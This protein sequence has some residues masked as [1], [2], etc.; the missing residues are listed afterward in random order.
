VRCAAFAL[1]AILP[2]AV[3]AE[4]I[5]FGLFGDMPYSKW[6]RAQMPRLIEQ[7]DSENLAFVVHG[8]D[9]KSGSSVCSDA[10]FSD[11]LGVFQASAHPLIY[12]PGDNEWTDCHRKS[13]GRHDPLERL[14]KLRSLFFPDDF[15]LGQ[16]RLRLERQSADPRYA[17]YRENVRWATGGVL[18]VGLNVPGSDN[19][20]NGTGREPVPAREFVER[21]RANQAWLAQAFS[22]ARGRGTRGLMIVIQAN[23]DF[24]A[25]QAGK[26]TQGYRDFL[27]QLREETQSFAGEVVLVHG[28]THSHRI[29][30]PLLEPR[31][32]EPLKNFTRL[33]TYGSPFPGWIRVTIDP[34]APKLF[35][36][37]A[38][39]YREERPAQ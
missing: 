24:E 39:P 7:M 17:A 35:R 34:A 28:D 37:E 29:D 6:E 11:I 2:F 15:S 1:L 23:P 5:S 22:D 19:N 12:V 33:E 26:P 9:I 36:F 31:T 4:P 32:G 18:F 3:H 16:R 27:W 13:N 14:E 10:A 8:G 30:Q 38:R 21:S 25:L 20:Y